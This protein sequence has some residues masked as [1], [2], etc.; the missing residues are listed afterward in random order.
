MG[1]MP[2]KIPVQE[3]VADCFTIEVP[4]IM[5]EKAFPRHSHACVGV[6]EQEGIIFE[7]FNFFGMLENLEVSERCYTL[8][9]LFSTP[10]SKV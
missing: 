5:S 6:F 2:R 9:N 4:E 1:H 3:S 7:Q 10:L 8:I